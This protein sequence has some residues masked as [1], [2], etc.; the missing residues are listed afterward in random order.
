MSLNIVLFEPRDHGNV[1]NIAR[2]VVAFNATLHL[3][4]P[5]GFIIPKQG[6]KRE[7]AGHWNEAKIVEY[8]DI[9]DFFNRLDTTKNNIHYLYTRYGLH[10]PGE[11]DYD[12]NNEIYLWFGRED[13]GLPFDLLKEYKETTIRIPTSQNMRSINL[14]NTVAIASFV[15]L[16]KNNFKEMCLDEPHKKN[17]LK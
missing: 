1:G 17:P 6:Y 7:A 16:E 12:L 9:E 11:F 14:S 10:S 8:L 15:V 4:R 13:V 2:T 3:I 5:Y